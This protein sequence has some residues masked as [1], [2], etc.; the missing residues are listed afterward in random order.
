MFLPGIGAV[1]GLALG[2]GWY[3][4]SAKRLVSTSKQKSA[5]ILKKAKE[6]A[7]KMLDE[8]RAELD[9][10][11]KE[12]EE[13]QL[14]QGERIKRL[15]DRLNNKEEHVRRREQ[16]MQSRKQHMEEDAVA[17]DGIQAQIEEARKKEIAGLS[18]ACGVPVE[19]A[20]ET[21]L[22]QINEELEQDKLERLHNIDAHI[23]EEAEEKARAAVINA[24][25]KYALPASR[26][27]KSMMIDISNKKLRDRLLGKRQR[28][29]QE[30]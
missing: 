27:S 9:S 21:L 30:A 19:S 17:L 20:K 25:Q 22:T 5:H 13:E 12:H 15:E 16:S 2:F 26:E 6:D 24:I 7:Q 28:E 29:Y 14:V 18:K 8:A 1:V 23:E 10:Y 11:K 4:F 3:V